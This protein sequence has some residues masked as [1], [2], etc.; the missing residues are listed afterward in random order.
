MSGPI[1]SRVALL[2]LVVSLI[3]GGPATA[4]LG[5]SSV[6]D[7]IR[8]QTATV[9]G[10]PVVEDVPLAV[11]DRTTLVN[12]LAAD[13]NSERGVREFLTSQMLLEVL[14][15]IP[16]GGFDLRE[17]QLSLLSEQLVAAYDYDDR[18]MY[19]VSDAGELAP[20]DKVAI[21]HEMTH[22]LQDQHFGLRR[23][24][25]RQPANADAQM[26]AQ[27]LV[28]GDAMVTMFQW[29]RRYLSAGE[30]RAMDTPATSDERLDSAPQ[31]VRDEFLFP[32]NEGFFFAQ[33]LFQDGG[34]DAIDRAFLD[35]PRSTEQILHP[36]KYAAREAPQPVAMP[37]LASVLG[38]TWNSLR[39][40]TFGELDLRLLL[41]QFL[42]WPAAEVAATGWGG[43]SYTILED[44]SGRRIV[45]ILTTWDTPGD[46]AEF[47]NAFV[48]SITRRFGA[49]Q[50]RT[51]EQPSVARWTVPG[52]QIQ[53]LT[54]GNMVR[55]VYAPDAAILDIVDEHLANGAGA[56]PAVAPT[57]SVF[58][59]T[60]T[61]A[62][63]DQS[64]GS[65]VATPATPT[66]ATEPATAEPATTE[67]APRTPAGTD[68]AP[69]EPGE[70]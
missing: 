37:P 21:S 69:P 22:A 48:Q 25:P 36:E 19:L 20:Q 53:A 43:D 29:G 16:E 51:V 47:Y 15:L 17:F 13:V 28:E 12:R 46:A 57:P 3:A 18:A 44:G 41:Q 24:L 35:P 66:P 49:A 60:P 6:V 10:L 55:L 42:G 58:E 2:A 1:R 64:P 54:S 26:A 67:P 61:P 32:Y 63:T 40:D 56:V 9:R 7:E 14:G 5:Q 39:V 52:Y 45:A 50:V 62:D 31:I 30:K 33:Q 65:S 59:P 68:E 8:Q 34:F 38:G 70:P 27:A 11:V 4:A 23:L